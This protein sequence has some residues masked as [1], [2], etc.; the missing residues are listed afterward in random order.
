MFN[1]SIF[2]SWNSH[3]I[4]EKYINKIVIIL[5]NLYVKKLQK[6]AKKHY[7]KTIFSLVASLFANTQKIYK[8]MYEDTYC[9]YTYTYVLQCI[10]CIISENQ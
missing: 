2:S 5:I 1:N 7:T 8:C 6:S 10:Y 3:T 4:I 9:I